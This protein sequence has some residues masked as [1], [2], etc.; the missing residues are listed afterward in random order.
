MYLFS[1]QQPQLLFLKIAGG[2]YTLT[3]L[4]AAI[5]AIWL[6]RVGGSWMILVAALSAIAL[7]VQ[8]ITRYQRSDGL[9]VLI[10]GVLWWILIASI[11]AVIGLM[12]LKSE[13][14]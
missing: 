6:K 2:L 11:P 3:L 9:L 13:G 5:C 14:S 8:E 4:P 7:S 12:I 1:F 10:A